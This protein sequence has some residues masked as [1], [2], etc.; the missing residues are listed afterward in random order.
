MELCA[1]PPGS[2]IG[3]MTLREWIDDTNLRDPLKGFE[4][5]T[6]L[7][8][9]VRHIHRARFVHRDLK[10]ANVFVQLQPKIL[11]KIGDFGLAS[12]VKGLVHRIKKIY[13]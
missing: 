2:K 1:A 9:G 11:V 8:K 4:I 6:S 3:I 7:M 13:I 5:F 10:P 12:T